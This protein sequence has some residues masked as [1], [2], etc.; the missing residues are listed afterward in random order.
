VSGPDSRIRLGCLARGRAPAARKSSTTSVSRLINIAATA[1]AHVSG[2]LED[3]PKTYRRHGGISRRLLIEI[4]IYAK[5]CCRPPDYLHPRRIGRRASRVRQSPSVSRRPLFPSFT[6]TSSRVRSASSRAPTR[7][8]VSPWC[9]TVHLGDRDGA[10][11][12]EVRALLALQFL[13]L[14]GFVMKCAHRSASLPVV[15]I[16]PHYLK[17]R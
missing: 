15:G 6:F 3:K 7:D 13:I 16:A 4:W 1:A 11:R 2:S 17:V 8:G 12:A 5:E 10:L 9:P 14:P